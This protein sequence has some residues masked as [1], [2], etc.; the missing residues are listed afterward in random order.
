M[1]D[2]N[3]L[4][5]EE[6]SSPT[7]FPDIFQAS[8]NDNEMITNHLSHD[9]IDVSDTSSYSP[10]QSTRATHRVQFHGENETLSSAS[11]VNFMLLCN[12]MQGGQITVKFLN[13][14][15]NQLKYYSEI[16]NELI[17]KI[18]KFTK[19]ECFNSILFNGF[20]HGISCLHCL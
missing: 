20:L 14:L 17:C 11:N 4:E 8:S 5:R 18:I 6:P 1:Q 13:R 9:T 10:K 16:N 7:S 15:F 3:P 19:F 2:L 12:W